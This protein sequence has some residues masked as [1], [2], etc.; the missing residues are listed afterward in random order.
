MVPALAAIAF[1]LF[2]IPAAMVTLRAGTFHMNAY[3]CVRVC[4]RAHQVGNQ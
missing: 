2:T 3:V 1:E 4:A